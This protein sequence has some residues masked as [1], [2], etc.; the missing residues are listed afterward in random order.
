MSTP[1]KADPRSL[2]SKRELKRAVVSLLSENPDISSLTV[3]KIADKAELN[4]ATFYLHY[5]DINDL[6]HHLVQEIFDDLSQKLAPFLEI[7][8]MKDE[9]KL[10][11]FLDYF[12]E[13]RKLFAV[14]FE[15]PQFK[16]K[17]HELLKDFVQNR[18]GIRGA[19]NRENLVSIDL[20]AASLLG[21]IMWWIKQGT[22]YS[23]E[24]IAHQISLMYQK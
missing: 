6:L 12:Y 4:R 7:E 18:R 15:G 10:L 9:E 8:S 5:L 14:L 1:K 17:L 20:L 24:Y 2:R 22:F 13:H 11:S 21:I 19:A 3:Q 16:I 23:S